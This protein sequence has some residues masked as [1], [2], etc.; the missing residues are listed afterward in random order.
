MSEELRILTIGHGLIGSQRARVLGKLSNI[1]PVTSAGIVDPNANDLPLDTLC[2]EEISDV[3]IEDYDAAIIAV[4]H[5]LATEIAIKV[6]SQG[7][8]VLVEKPLGINLSE[9]EAVCTA[10]ER[11]TIPSFVGYNYRF[12]PTVE[13]AIAS[14][15]EGRLGA[16]RSVNMLIG[17]GG[18]PRS[19]DGWKLDPKLAGGGVLL[20]PGVHLLDLLLCVCPD[21]RCTHVAATSGFWGTGV[22]EDLIATFETSQILASMR[23]SHIRWINTFLIEIGGEDGYAIIEGRGGNYGPQT[24]RIGRRWGWNETEGQT[25]KETEEVQ[26]FGPDNQSLDVELE[27]IVRR[28][29]GEPSVDG[30]QHPATMGESLRITELYSEMYSMM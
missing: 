15:T 17:H 9:A 13:K 20:D 10:A 30:N 25:Q 23:V 8:P 11:N 1:L 18:H 26:D 6:L 3:P 16:L 7:K 27:H 14:L 5:H 22:E 4:P 12:L 2:F 24:V 29:L 28:W 21:I 19:A